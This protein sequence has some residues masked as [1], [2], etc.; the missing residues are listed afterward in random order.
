[1]KKEIQDKIDAIKK[2]AKASK[3]S[4][5]GTTTRRLSGE[6]DSLSKAITNKVDAAIFLAELDTLIKLAN[7]EQ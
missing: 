1:V 6:E 4:S 3:M 5:S 2:Q 7:E